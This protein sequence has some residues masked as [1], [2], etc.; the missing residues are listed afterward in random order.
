VDQIPGLGRRAAQPGQ[1]AGEERQG[2]GDR[3]RRELHA[4]SLEQRPPAFLIRRLQD[5]AGTAD[6]SADWPPGPGMLAWGRPRRST[7]S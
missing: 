7:T 1:G 2:T 6:P 3:S 5:R 4:A